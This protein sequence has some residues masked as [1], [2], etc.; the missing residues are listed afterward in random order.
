MMA[1][2]TSEKVKEKREKLLQLAKGSTGEPMVTE[3]NYQLELCKAL[4]YYNNFYDFKTKRSWVSKYCKKHG[5]QEEL[6]I[7]EGDAADYHF[8]QVGAI[9][10]L[11]DRGQYVSS[12]HQK[13]IFGKLFEIKKTDERIKEDNKKF[14]KQTP[15]VD[16][17]ELITDKCMGE[18]NG[19]IDNFINTKSTKFDPT[20]YFKANDI[21]KAV[22]KNI[23]TILAKTSEE[24]ESVDSDEQLTEGYSNFS[25]REMKKFKEMIDGIISACDQQKVTS[26]K[27][28]KIRKVKEKPVSVQVKNV[29]YAIKGDVGGL[30]LRSVS[31]E[32]LIGA[33]EVWFYY[34]K[35]RTI[36]VYKSD[37]G[38]GIKGTKLVDFSVAKSFGKKVRDPKTLLSKPLAKA[39]LAEAFDE[40]KSKQFSPNGRLSEET[41]ILK[42]F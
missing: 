41:I 25:K 8:Y 16:R 17:T 5:M 26:K 36:H 1:A 2:A 42:V 13:T 37:T 32:S 4:S 30:E 15:V 28:K 35:H 39:S 7:V 9:C 33:K 23:S 21:P 38:M 22:A 20:A 29:K 12:E 24:L 3:G 31:P 27:S 34:L 19:E 14:Q 18:I 6:K 10:R 11:L 40:L